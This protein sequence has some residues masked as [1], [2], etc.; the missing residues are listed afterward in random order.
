MT[1]EGFPPFEYFDIKTR[2]HRMEKHVR[3]NFPEFYEFIIHN[4]PEELTWTEKLYWYYHGLTEKPKCIECGGPIKFKNFDKGYYQYCSHKCCFSSP[5]RMQRMNDTIIK[6]YGVSNVSQLDSIKK[7]KEET[8]EKHYGVRHLLQSKEYQ[9]QLK[10]TMIEKYG[11]EYAHQSQEI[12]AKT[13]QTNLERYGGVGFES[14]I[15]NEKSRQTNLERYGVEN[16]YQLPEVVE[17]RKR[18]CLEK[19]GTENPFLSDTFKEQLKQY[20]LDK[21]G[22]EYAIQSEEVREKIKQ[23]NLERYGVENPSVINEIKEKVKQTNLERYGKEYYTQTDEYRNIIYDK[24]DETNLKRYNTHKKNKS[25]NTSKIEK[26][27]TEWL[28]KNF[29]DFKKEYK[30]EEYP[31]RCDYYFP[32][33]NIYLEVQGHQTHG[34]HP[35]NP[36]DPNDVKKLE[37]LK[38]KDPYNTIKVWTIRDPMKRAWAKD[39]NLNWHEIFT[40][41][42]NDLI[43]WCK[44]QNIV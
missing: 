29:I 8:L 23:T 14:T 28:N 32:K 39:H 7:K 26:N 31:F 41:D 30:C 5:I 19:F 9:Q 11:V 3:N 4:Y 34:G 27:F 42:L 40:N 18:A 2:G 15:L 44:S 35:F 16:P 6:K 33:N 38:I 10:E 21:Y 22:V 13:R 37:K 43:E 12:K 1:T 24:M 36:E 25:F 20:N 17:N